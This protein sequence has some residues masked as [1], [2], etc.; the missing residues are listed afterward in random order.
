[1][2][3]LLR[4]PKAMAQYDSDCVDQ[5]LQ[6]HIPRTTGRVETDGGG[7]GA[8]LKQTS[9]GYLVKATGR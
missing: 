8:P 4:A 2:N 9:L 6:S 1:M 3:I 7:G 5:I